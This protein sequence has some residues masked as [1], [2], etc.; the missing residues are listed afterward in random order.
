M[1]TDH[2]FE[3]KDLD[4]IHDELRAIFNKL[5]QILTAIRNK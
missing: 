1:S 3:N 5:D 2:N 4:A